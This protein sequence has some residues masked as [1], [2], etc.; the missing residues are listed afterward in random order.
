[1]QDIKEQIK[2]NLNILKNELAYYGAIKTKEKNKYSCPI[3][4]S[5]S[6]LH[7][8]EDTVTY[9]CYDV[10][11]QKGGDVFNFVA[12][13][14]GLDIKNDFPNI[15][16]II[17]DRQGIILPTNLKKL[18]KEDT[19]KIKKVKKL[20]TVEIEAKEKAKE[21]A[22]KALLKAVELHEEGNYNEEYFDALA[23]AE[24]GEEE[25][26]KEDIYKSELI[27]SLVINKNNTTSVNILKAGK[28]ILKRY[29]FIYNDSL[30]YKYN[31][32]IGIWEKCNNKLIK[33]IVTRDLEENCDYYSSST[34][35][36]ISKYIMDKTYNNVIGSD[37]NSVF[38]KDIYT[39]TFKNGVFN[40]FENRFTN[41]F[42]KDNY[43][44]IRI[45]YNYNEKAELPKKTISFI[46]MMT[47]SIEEINFIFEWIGYCFVSGYPIQ[48]ML[49]IPG[50]GG[51]GK[52]TL[53]KLISNVI[54]ID[55]NS[56]ISM[57]QL[58]SNRFASSMLHNKLMNSVADIGADFFDDSSTIKALT[59]DDY[60]AVERKGENVVQY[61]N[62][63]KLVYS[64][65]TLPKFKDVTEGFKR[66]PIVLPLTKD[67]TSIVKT[68]GLNIDDILNDTKEI[69]RI[70]KYSLEKFQGVIK[71]N[72]QFTESDTMRETKESWI[73]SNPL[74]DF[75]DEAFEITKK[76]EDIITIQEFNK[77]YRVYCD[78]RG[79]KRLSQNTLIEHIKT[80][81]NTKGIE[82]KRQS[83]KNKIYNVVGLKLTSQ[84]F[85]ECKNNGVV[86]LNTK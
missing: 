45:P 84:I 63:A 8:Y 82:V 22:N 83:S 48:K 81:L 44:T 59:G 71:R 9:H 6:N 51:N 69:E 13:M 28:A 37:F 78:D 24:W 56:N 29:D 11:C 75:I 85:E 86:F 52:S 61:K 32:N 73:N 18:T 65:N 33:S 53:I 19:L 60:I 35:D 77:L 40:I 16:K 50:G 20:K 68:S 57:K 47:D 3:C 1:M 34:T 72:M 43:S 58:I 76:P 31:E 67:F 5:K 54:G 64:C 55:N 80:F 23:V 2:S 66:R 14:E 62:F 30:H 26:S 25:I 17:A 4:G 49:F 10:N 36:N 7:L 15:L 41:Q 27:N 79:Y 39:I 12:N 21:K 38:N 46:G 42:K 70:I 74:I